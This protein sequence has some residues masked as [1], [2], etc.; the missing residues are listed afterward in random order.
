VLTD[1]YTFGADATLGKSFGQCE[2]TYMEAFM[3]STGVDGNTD[4][5]ALSGLTGA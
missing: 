4:E 2:S 3:S 1:R 5:R